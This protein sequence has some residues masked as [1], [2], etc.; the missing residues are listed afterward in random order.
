MNRPTNPVEQC[1]SCHMQS[2]FDTCSA[3]RR[4]INKDDKGEFYKAIDCKLWVERVIE[5]NESGQKVCPT[6]GQVIPNETS[7][8]IPIDVIDNVT[9]TFDDSTVFEWGASQIEIKGVPEMQE[10]INQQYNK[11]ID[12]V[13]LSSNATPIPTE[14]IK[15][16]RGNPGGPR[17]R[18]FADMPKA[19]YGSGKRKEVKNETN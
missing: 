16:G 2:L 18:G 9:K 15:R 1:P 8:P 11:L 7:E 10:Q 12:N 19:K 6:C 4:R 3:G 13:V 5:K 17:K 14:L